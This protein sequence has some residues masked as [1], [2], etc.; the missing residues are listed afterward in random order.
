[1]VPTWT[2]NQTKMVSADCMC[3]PSRLEMG[4]EGC[5]GEFLGPKSN[6]GNTKVGPAGTKA[7]ST[8]PKGGPTGPKGSPTGGKVSESDRF[9]NN[10]KAKG[11]PYI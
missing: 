7:S 11:W 4:I 10:F 5:A 1:M 2:P 8:S 3:F 9:E 6:Q